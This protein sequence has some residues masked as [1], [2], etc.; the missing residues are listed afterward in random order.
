MTFNEQMTELMDARFRKIFLND[1]IANNSHESWEIGGGP[2][3]H[4]A[5][6]NEVRDANNK[7]ILSWVENV[8]D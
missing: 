4:T 3:G 2:V 8:K 6:M 1:L 7:L 5:F